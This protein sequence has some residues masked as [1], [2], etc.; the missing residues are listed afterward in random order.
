MQTFFPDQ[1]L[2]KVADFRGLK[3][4][5]EG[6]RRIVAPFD[7]KGRELSHDRFEQVFKLRI[8][9]GVLVVRDIGGDGNLFG[10]PII[11]LLRP[12]HGPGPLIGE[13]LQLIR[14]TG[15]KKG[16]CRHNFFSYLSG[17]RYSGDTAG[18]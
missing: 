12:R 15:T 18:D 5:K 9:G 17:Y 14:I 10:G 8:N 4:G 1:S 16:F 11:I 13:G 3:N 2:E 7:V 6:L